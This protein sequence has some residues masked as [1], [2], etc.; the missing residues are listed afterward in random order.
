MSATEGGYGQGVRY[1]SSYVHLRT[2]KV[3]S[4]YDAH[5]DKLLTF[6][7]FLNIVGPLNPPNSLFS[8]FGQLER[9]PLVLLSPSRLEEDKP[10]VHLI[11]WLEHKDKRGA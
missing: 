4:R 1:V 8:T 10:L 9:R 11:F 7:T 5:N 2:F 6:L 3:L